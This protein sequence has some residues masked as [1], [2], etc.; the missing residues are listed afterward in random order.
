MSNYRTI[1]LI[2]AAGSGSRA[3]GDI[4]KQYRDIGGI[5]ILRKTALAFLNHDKIDAVQIVY[6]PA[7][8]DLYQ[9]TTTG[10]DLLPV[11]KGGKTRQESVRLGLESIKKYN[12][13][14]VLIHDAARPFVGKNIINRVIDSITENK[15]VIPTIAV[16][17]TLKKCENGKII[18]T[19]NRHDLM[20]AQTPQGF[21][22]NDVLNM[23]KNAKNHEFTDD[24]AIYEHEGNEVIMVEGSQLNFKI[25]TNEDFVRAQKLAGEYMQTRIGTGFDVHKFCEPKNDNNHI[26]LCAIAVPF[27]K[28]LEG[29]SDADVGIHALVDSLLGA[30]ALGDIGEHFPPSDKK[31]KDANSSIFLEHTKSLLDRNNI[32]INNI[33]LTIICEKPKISVYKQDMVAK[34]AQILQIAPSCVSVKATTTEG[35]GFTGRGEG[36]AAQAVSAVRIQG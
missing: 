34:I 13:R 15:A 16:E 24:A 1:A 27:E 2:V 25:T 22:Y 28:S 17:D 7:D 30:A 11:A 14:K 19:V 32:K 9:K 23:H 18:H 35:L 4:P 31:F 20:R 6:N 21:I 5:P 26:M 36:I 12:P 10:L 8:N 3:E 29:H 33:D